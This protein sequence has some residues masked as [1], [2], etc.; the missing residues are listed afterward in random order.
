MACASSPGVHTCLY[1]QIKVCFRMVSFTDT[2]TKLEFLGVRGKG[3]PGRL[4]L[5][6]ALY[7][8]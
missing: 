1:V 7:C 2:G 5:T 8:I 6:Y 4:V 3:Q